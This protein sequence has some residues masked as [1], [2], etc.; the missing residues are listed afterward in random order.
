MG[1]ILEKRTFDA[2]RYDIVCTG[3]LAAGETIASIVSIGADQ[4]GL[5]FA[6]AVVNSQQ[7]AYDNDVTVDVGKAIQVEISGGTIPPDADSRILGVPNLLCTV[8]A[9]FT[10]SLSPN[11]IEATV[12]LLLCDDPHER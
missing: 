6:G 11:Q 8:R 9:R 4:G 3:L 7:L 5:T 12:L 1:Q 10:T 2:R